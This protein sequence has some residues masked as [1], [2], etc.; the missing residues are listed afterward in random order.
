[1]LRIIISGSRNLKGYEFFERICLDIISKEQY[2]REIDNKQ[3]EIVSGNN[4]GG[5]DHYGEK[6][7]EKWLAKK[8]TLFPADWNDMSPPVVVGNG[9]YGTYNKLAGNKRNTKM[10]NYLLSGESG[11]VIAFD[12]EESK[13][14]TG[15]R[16][17]ITISRKYG[18]KTYHIK[19]Y[20]QHNVETKIY[21]GDK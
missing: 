20:D 4:P 17:M 18:F 21:N 16:D 12:A 11:V 3:I 10:A 8:A 2:D 5:A 14:K 13:K 6:F 15:T 7:S 1:M 19:C 9:F